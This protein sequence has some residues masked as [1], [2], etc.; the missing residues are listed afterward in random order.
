MKITGA[1]RGLKAIAL[2]AMMALAMGQVMAASSSKPEPATKPPEERAMSFVVARLATPACEPNCP[3]WIAADGKIMDNTPAKL[4][5]LLANPAYRKLPILINSG[6]GRVFAAMEMGRIIRKYGM[7]TA[8]GLTAFKACSPY[9]ADKPC[10]PDQDSTAYEADAW[11][12]SARCFSACPLM[13]LGGKTRIVDE[14]SRLGL[15]EPVDELHPYVDHYWITWR[16]ENGRKHIVSRRFVNRTYLKPKTVVGVTAQL[17]IRLL[18]YLKEMGA[19]QDVIDEMNKA[20]PKDINLITYYG[21]RRQQL[22]L[23][24]KNET[25]LSALTKFDHCAGEG[26]FPANCVFMKG[27]S[28]QLAQPADAPCFILGGCS[29]T[30]APPQQAPAEASCL[31]LSGCDKMKGPQLVRPKNSQCFILGGCT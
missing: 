12:F 19:S 21:G 1:W 20:S 8:V 29:K 22:G 30:Q 24:S 23:V 15:H 11:P 16:M 13:L 31:E 2:I 28:P 18:P 3:E 17:R 4:A 26:P 7:D 27:R 9:I 10:E 14:A 25:P 5:K 6:G